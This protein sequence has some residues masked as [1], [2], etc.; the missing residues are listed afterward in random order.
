MCSEKI[1]AGLSSEPETVSDTLHGIGFISTELLREVA[2]VP[3]TKMTNARKLY[4]SILETVKHHSHRYFDF[5]SILRSNTRLYGDLLKV[6]E[7]TCQEKE[8]R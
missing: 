4:I 8:K 5:I 3:A 6:L 1:V 2:E 7:E